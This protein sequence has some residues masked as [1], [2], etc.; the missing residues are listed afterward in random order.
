L[1]KS[2][3]PT[4]PI[5]LCIQQ[6]SKGWEAKICS[7]E[8]PRKKHEYSHH[9]PDGISDFLC[10]DLPGIDFVK[11]RK[12]QERWN[13]NDQKCLLEDIKRSWESILH[14]STQ[15]SHPITDQGFLDGFKE[16]FNEIWKFITG[17]TAFI[18]DAMKAVVKALVDHGFKEKDASDLVKELTANINE[19]KDKNNNH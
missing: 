13:E 10:I 11:D 5:L 18:T 14:W 7:C 15:T 19:N 12:E 4:V 1:I 2:L 3:L 16:W 17:K 9:A 6:S 8:N